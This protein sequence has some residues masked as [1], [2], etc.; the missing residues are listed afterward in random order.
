MFAKKTAISL[1][2]SIIFNATA[3]LPAAAQSAES[4]EMT[5]PSPIPAAARE[6]GVIINT[7]VINYAQAAAFCIQSFP[8]RVTR[9]GKWSA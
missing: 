8:V 6:M 9:I 4:E 7:N 5:D 1:I 2:I 3:V